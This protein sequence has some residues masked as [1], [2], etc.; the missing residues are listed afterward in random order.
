MNNSIINLSAFGFKEKYYITLEGKVFNQDKKCY[1]NINK[2]YNLKLQTKENK[3]ICISLKSLYRQAFN[4]EYCIDIVDDL[5][6]EVW[7]CVPYSRGRYY[8][9][10]Y[11]RVK[12]LCH[13]KSRLLKPFKNSKGYYYVSINNKKRFVHRI[14]A[15]AFI[16]TKSKVEE[17]LQ[18]HHKDKN[19]ENNCVDN[20]EWL[21]VSE[22]RKQHSKET[23]K[24]CM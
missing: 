10:N 3:F 22:H 5:Q 11:G 18:V 2:K 13:Y 6:N 20:L 1:V 24:E 7:V 9:S 17:E 16:E 19:K 12:S 4:K 23:K 15:N 21:T 8:V 14:V